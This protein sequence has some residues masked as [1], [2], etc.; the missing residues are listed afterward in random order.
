MPLVP[1]LTYPGL[2]SPH[3]QSDT[4][5]LTPHQCTVRERAKRI[6]ELLD[7]REA[8][9][10][11]R[12]KAK[13]NRSKYVGQEGGAYCFSG[14]GNRD[15]SRSGGFGGYSSGYDDSYDRERKEREEREERRRKEE[16]E[17]RRRKE[18]AEEEERKRKEREAAELRAKEAQVL[19]GLS[20]T[21]DT[22]SWL[23]LSSL[24]V[25]IRDISHNTFL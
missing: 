5:N 11:E 18:E 12:Q 1:L 25:H 15:Y 13:A 4:P 7:D 22:A 3:R 9:A 10:D 19:I 16:E 20:T 6:L 24:Y 17:E 23:P 14:Y 2:H 21:R 8:I